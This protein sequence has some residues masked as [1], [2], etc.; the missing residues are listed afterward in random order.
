MLHE[1]RVLFFLPSASIKIIVQLSDD[2][3][4]DLDAIA[5]NAF[6]ILDTCP[7]VAEDFVADQHL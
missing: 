2:A 3:L 7:I 5:L 6:D 4:S 1:N